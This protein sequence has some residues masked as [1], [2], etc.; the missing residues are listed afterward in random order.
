MAY[1]VVVLPS[2]LADLEGLAPAVRR[3]VLRRL[4]WLGQNASQVI[5]HRLANL[6]DA[7]SGLCRFRVGDYRILYWAYPQN[8]LLKIYRIEH[9]REVYDHLKP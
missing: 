1:R 3:R 5:H 6:P 2:A 8:R 7:L 4:V 9:R